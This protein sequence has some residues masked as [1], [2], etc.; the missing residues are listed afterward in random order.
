MKRPWRWFTFVFLVF[1][2]IPMGYAS[3]WDAGVVLQPENSGDQELSD[4]L[5]E[6]LISA[7]IEG[8]GRK[9]R[10]IGKERVRTQLGLAD[11]GHGFCVSDAQ[12]LRRVRKEL[13]LSILAVGRVGKVPSGYR[14]NVL[15]LGSRPQTDRVFGQRDVPDLGTLIEVMSEVASWILRVEDAALTVTVVP[16][17]ARVF[18]NGT[19]QKGGGTFAVTPGKVEVRCSH[20]EYPEKV[21][22]VMCISGALCAVQM[23][24]WMRG[25]WLFP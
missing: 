22:T 7:I 1:C 16:E 20:P 15:W 19:L 6:V 24:L 9:V 5:T 13:G 3:E 18:V 21:E 4:D 23:S 25:R 8:S 12:C 14:L 11:S 17:D 10:V 2:W